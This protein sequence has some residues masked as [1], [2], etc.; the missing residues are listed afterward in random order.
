MM[1]VVATVVVGLFHYWILRF[2]WGI[3]YNMGYL[4]GQAIGECRAMQVLG[5]LGKKR[6][7]TS[8]VDDAFLKE[9]DEKISNAS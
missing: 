6:G 4:W 9:F 3:G 1:T 8:I 5:E 2:F 7:M